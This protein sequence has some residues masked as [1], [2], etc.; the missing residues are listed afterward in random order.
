[1]IGTMIRSWADLPALDDKP[2]SIRRQVEALVAASGGRIFGAH[3]AATRTYYYTIE[4]AD[5]ER[6]EI[7]DADHDNYHPWIGFGPIPIPKTQIN[8]GDSKAALGIK[9][10]ARWLGYDEATIRASN[11]NTVKGMVAILE[12][13]RS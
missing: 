10:L 3:N 7:R 12:S 8:I 5:G 9:L 2:E 6:I 4:R 1:M 11:V 13:S